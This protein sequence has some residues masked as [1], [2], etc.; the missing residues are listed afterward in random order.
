[1]VAQNYGLYMDCSDE[2]ID[3]GDSESD[4]NIEIDL[5]MVMAMVTVMMVMVYAYGIICRTTRKKQ[6]YRMCQC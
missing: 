4:D 6:R 5:V 1:M 3:G 2:G